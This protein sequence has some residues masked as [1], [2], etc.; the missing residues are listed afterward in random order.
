MVGIAVAAFARDWEPLKAVIGPDGLNDWMW[1]HACDAPET[2]ATVHFYKH[3]WSRRYVRLDAAGRVY[4]ETRDGQPR[5]LP[6]CG[7][8]TLLLVL[9]AA[10]AHHK[11]GLPPVITL[12]EPARKPSTV[13]D[14]RTLDALLLAVSD[15]YRA[16]LRQLDPAPAATAAHGRDPEAQE[17]GS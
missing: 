17:G 11:P 1:M 6:A 13:Q 10:C 14:L 16:T 7:G 12:P 5:L 4:G 9:M 8:A 15:G 2:G 3:V